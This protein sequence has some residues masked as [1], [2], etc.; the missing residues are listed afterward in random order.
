MKRAHLLVIILTMVMI[1]GFAAIAGASDQP[2][3][4][5][6][7]APKAMP[8]EGSKAM[9]MEGP[10]AMAAEGPKGIEHMIAESQIRPMEILVKVSG[11]SPEQVKMLIM[12]KG[13][14][15]AAQQ[16][17]AADA[18][19]TA[20]VQKRF[21]MIDFLVAKNKIGLKQALLVKMAFLRRVMTLVSEKQMGQGMMGGMMSK[22]G[23]NCQMMEGEGSGMMG[24]GMG[25]GAKAGEGKMGQSQGTEATA[26]PEGDKPEAAKPETAV[27]VTAPEHQH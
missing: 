19:V 27:P 11:K 9:P 18:L 15:A 12:H 26:A 1:A 25:D 22:A 3:D 16:L 17:K 23:C 20:M 13:M 5:P 4:S 24:K 14:W 21:A 8:M 7:S 6:M 2:G 10:K